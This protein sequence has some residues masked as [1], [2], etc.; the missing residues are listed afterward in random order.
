MA[1]CDWGGSND[2][3]M[4]YHADEWGVPV[5]NDTK[6]FEFLMMEAMQCG[7]N[8]NM[9]L[10]KREIFKACFDGFD[11]DKVAEYSEAEIQRILATPGMIRSR[12]K[13]EAVIRNAR[14]FQKIREEFGSFDQYLW[15]YSHGKTILYHGHER[16]AIPASNG[17]SDKISRDLKVRGFKY[18]GS[19]TVYSHLQACGVINDH[20]ENCPCFAQINNAYPTM[21]KRR[22][23][24]KG[25]RYLGGR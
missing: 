7:L 20:D 21:Q 9:V 23:L 18:L 3:L 8:W 13:I 14:R 11:Y 5:H 4:R 2:L 25:V 16:G 24:E 17:L 12:R 10:Q 1:Y 15:R 6:Q 19:I 22:F